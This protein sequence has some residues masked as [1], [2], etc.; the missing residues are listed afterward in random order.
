VE[1]AGRKAGV[2]VKSVEELVA[3]LKDEAGVL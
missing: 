2:M 1:P 3:K